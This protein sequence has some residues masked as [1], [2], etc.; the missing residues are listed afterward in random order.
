MHPGAHTAPARRAS[1]KRTSLRPRV[2]R[3]TAQRRARSSERATLRPQVSKSTALSRARS[4]PRRLAL[5][6][7]LPGRRKA[8]CLPEGMHSVFG[9]GTPVRAQLNQETVTEA[10]ML[11]EM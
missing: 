6:K 2:F 1:P 7:E 5:A 8:R 3:N 10:K 4:E 11:K 9:C